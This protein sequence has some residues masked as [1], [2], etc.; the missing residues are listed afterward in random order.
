MDSL[1]ALQ[2]ICYLKKA[3]NPPNLPIT[4]LY[5]NTSLAQLLESIA[6]VSYKK[7]S[8][9]AANTADRSHMIEETFKQYYQLVEQISS[10][11]ELAVDPSLD[12]K[13]VHLVVFILKGSTGSLSSYIL[14]T[15]LKTASVS[16]IYCLDRQSDSHLRHLKKNQDFNKP[17][18][19]TVSKVTFF[20]ADLSQLGL[21]LDLQSV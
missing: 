11:H 18:N 13:R 16:H 21:G 15:L 20:K 7:S 10:T 12:N 3:L 1:Q 17:V 2:F 4:I 5:T 8:S 6:D 9:K 19:F 14:R